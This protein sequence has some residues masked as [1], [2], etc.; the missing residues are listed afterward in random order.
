[1]YKNKEN[2][3]YLTI[4]LLAIIAV[5]VGTLA[6]SPMVQISLAQTTAGQLGQKAGEA[7]KSMAGQVM[8]GNKTGNQTGNQSGNTLA[9]VAGAVKGIMG[10]K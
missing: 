6:V 1:M 2:S 4:S 10:G 7:A 9:K 3:K 8:S 5:L